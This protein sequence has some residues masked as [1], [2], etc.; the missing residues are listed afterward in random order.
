M[1]LKGPD[2][3]GWPFE[4]NPEPIPCAEA[5]RPQTP[6]IAPA[7]GAP[8]VDETGKCRK[9]GFWHKFGDAVG[10]AIGEAFDNRGQS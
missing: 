10:E 7:C 6:V 8:D 1:T 2:S 9:C 5:P 3:T 4:P